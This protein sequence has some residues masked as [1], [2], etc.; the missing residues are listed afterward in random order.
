LALSFGILFERHETLTQADSI[1]SSMPIS[2]TCGGGAAAGV[3]VPCHYSGAARAS[4]SP[5]ACAHAPHPPTI[6]II[7]SR[8]RRG[9]NELVFSAAMEELTADP[10][11]ALPQHPSPLTRGRALHSNFSGDA[12][13]TSPHLLLLHTKCRFGLRTGLD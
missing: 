2:K 1:P 3:T 11:P 4:P 8:S 13:C 6:A 9:P 12:S 10:P 7:S 5:F